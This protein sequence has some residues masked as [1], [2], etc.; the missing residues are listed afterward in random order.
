MGVSGAPLLACVRGESTPFWPSSIPLQ[1]E[2]W[3]GWLGR[4][5]AGCQARRERPGAAW[6]SP[7]L[8]SDV[9]PGGPSPMECSRPALRPTLAR[10][11]PSPTLVWTALQAG[12][13]R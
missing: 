11:R 7:G 4:G 5:W 3:G 2:R 13:P 9:A 6:L 8:C 12:D 10:A 1:R